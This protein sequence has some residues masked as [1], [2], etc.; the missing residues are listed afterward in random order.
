MTDVPGALFGADKS[1]VANTMGNRSAILLYF[2]SERAM[3][4][5]LHGRLG[6]AEMHAQPLFADESPIEGSA[7]LSIVA[8]FGLVALVLRPAF[9]D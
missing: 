9:R 2:N 6:D 3:E 4:T 5:A 1:R 7:A 8:A